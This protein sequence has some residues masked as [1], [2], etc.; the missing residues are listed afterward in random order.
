MIG[1]VRLNSTYLLLSGAFC[2]LVIS[3]QLAFKK[4]IEAW[5]LNK[6]LELQINSATLSEQPTYLERQDK[7]LANIIKT[8]QTD[9]VNYRNNIA[10]QV[11]E[12]GDKEHVRIIEVPTQANLSTPRYLVQKVIL[13]GDFFA[14]LKTLNHLQQINGGGYIRSVLLKKNPNPDRAKDDKEIVMEVF[15]EVVK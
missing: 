5:Q 14:L 15:I 10:S 9:T 13:K 4:T 11:S 1:K 2:L 12:V 8:Y 6:K 7:A 3:Y